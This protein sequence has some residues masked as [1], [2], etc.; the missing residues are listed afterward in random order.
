MKT[1]L[2]YIGEYSKGLKPSNIYS[3]VN[4]L[5]KLGREPKWLE[6]KSS[7]VAYVDI[8]ELEKYMTLDN[9]AK[10]YANNNL[11]WLF[12]SLGYSNFSLSGLMAKKSKCFKSKHSWNYFF[13]V[14]LWSYSET[15]MFNPIDEP[16]MLSEFI[17]IGT[18]YIYLLNKAGKFE[19]KNEGIFGV[20]KEVPKM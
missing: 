5:K 18:R 20:S 13:S 7:K 1:N 10:D 9:R 12:M 4:K 2:V 11:Y 15:V 17:R 16:S 14:T 3:Q 19:V 6:R 8:N